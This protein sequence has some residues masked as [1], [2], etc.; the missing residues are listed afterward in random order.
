MNG[1]SQI[2]GKKYL[3]SFT[4]ANILTCIYSAKAVSDNVFKMIITAVGSFILTFANIDIA[5][6]VVGLSVLIITLILSAYMNGRVG[7]NPDEYTKKDI[8]IRK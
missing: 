7:L 6:I 1:T 2:L 8:Y 4:N 5:T 3:N